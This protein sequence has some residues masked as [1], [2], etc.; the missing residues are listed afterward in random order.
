MYVAAW[1]QMEYDDKY[2]K[3]INENITNDNAR[4][5]DKINWYTAGIR[6]IWKWSDL[7]ST[8]VEIG[9]DKVENA[10]SSY[11]S[12]NTKHTAVFDSE[13]Y[14]I[15]LAQQFHPK[16]GAFVR[17]VIRLF[18]TYADWKAPDSNQ[19][20]PTGSTAE[21]RNT[22]GMAGI[23]SKQNHVIDT[24]GKTS[25]GWTYGAQMEVWW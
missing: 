19:V 6:P 16:F 13:L 2:V 7:M 22:L 5:K 21:I 12:G 20:N 3:A 10:T 17:P 9:Y 23:T 8:A 14:K 4:M 24:F 1:N 25:S 11:T 15:T 18:A